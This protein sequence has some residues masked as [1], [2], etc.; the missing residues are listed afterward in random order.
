M[1]NAGRKRMEQAL[2]ESE[3][4]YRTLFESFALGEPHAATADGRSIEVDATVNVFEG[5]FACPP[6]LRPKIDYAIYVDAHDFVLEDRLA[7]IY[8]WMGKRL[9]DVEI[10]IASARRDEWPAVRQQIDF[11]DATMRPAQLIAAP[12]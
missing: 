6:E 4:K 3:E 9:D 7:T 8:R 2:M 5:L 12:R 1:L 10:A 11:A